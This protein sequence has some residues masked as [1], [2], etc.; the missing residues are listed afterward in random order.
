M[1]IPE[2]IES[3]KSPFSSFPRNLFQKTNAGICRI[4]RRLTQ[5][6]IGRAD[7]AALS[8]DVP[9]VFPGLRSRGAP[10]TPELPTASLR[11]CPSRG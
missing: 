5:V 3:H 8:R 6:G 2:E 10:S 7:A 9:G 1:F 4:P 11:L